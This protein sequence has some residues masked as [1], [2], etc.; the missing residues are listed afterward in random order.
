MKRALLML[1][2]LP[3]AAEAQWQIGGNIGLRTRP[4]GGDGNT[5]LGVQFEGMIVKVAG[6]SSYLAQ[7]AI[8]QMK[9]HNAAGLRVRENSLEGS[10]LYR[11]ALNSWLGAAVGPA[12]GYSTGCASGGRSGTGYGATA[13]VASYAEKGT[14]RPGYILQLDAAHV[15]AR[16]MTWRYGIRGTGHTVASGSKTPKP[17]VWA[18]FT[19]PFSSR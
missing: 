11:R 16:G 17:V 13:C 6:K 15:T 8:I 2:M 14:I 10:L 18:G 1:L 7:G 4:D 9:N 5:V 3:V 19:A 12:I